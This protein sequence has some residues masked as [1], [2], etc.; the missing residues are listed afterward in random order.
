MIYWKVV[1]PMFLF[2]INRTDLRYSPMFTI[3]PYSIPA[4]H[5]AQIWANS[6]VGFYHN[7]TTSTVY[8]FE[9]APAP[10]RSNLAH[11]IN[12]I[13][14]G[15]QSGMLWLTSENQLRKPVVYQWSCHETKSAQPCY[16][17]F[18]SLSGH[19]PPRN[20]ILFTRD[21]QTKKN[22][23]INSTWFQP[24]NQYLIGLQVFDAN[25]SKLS[26]ETEY[27]LLNVIEGA[28]PQ[29]FVG[30][31][32]IKGKYL[33]PY[34][35]R[36]STFLI[37]SGSKLVIKG[38]AYLRNGLRNISWESKNF[39]YPLSW[40]SSRVNYEEIHTELYIHEGW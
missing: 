34:N 29:V 4:N 7:Q 40:S 14:I 28:K 16:F 6:Y 8:T 35:T 10:I 9:P 30:P 12:K 39:R 36:F 1:D 26:S 17:N 33:V 37:P 38:H 18:G 21:I 11:G 13:T 31:V 15:S 5:S 3:E 27:T 19:I 2:P 32:Y 24:N 22:V 20:P 25:N 23:Y